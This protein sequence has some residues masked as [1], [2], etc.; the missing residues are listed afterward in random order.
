MN[1]PFLAILGVLVVVMGGAA[2]LV[3]E[4][5]ASEKPAVSAQLGQPLL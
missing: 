2:L 5:G 3:F 4:R 1:K